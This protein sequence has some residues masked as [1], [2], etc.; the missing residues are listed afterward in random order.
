MP[1][2][3]ELYELFCSLTMRD[4]RA[5]PWEELPPVV[6]GAWLAVKEACSK[7]EEPVKKKPPA[8]VGRKKKSRR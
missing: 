3:K 8:A 2:A 6:S 7:A 5:L 4:G 1:T